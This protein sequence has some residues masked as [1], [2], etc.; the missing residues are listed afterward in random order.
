MGT[1]K[2]EFDMNEPDE[3]EKAADIANDALGKLRLAMWNFSQDTLRKYRKY[4]VDAVT[5]DAIIKDAGFQIQS[6]EDLVQAVI[7]HLESQFYEAL[8]AQGASIE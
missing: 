3:Q 5:A 2:F 4:G 1:V 6:K 7:N 8:D